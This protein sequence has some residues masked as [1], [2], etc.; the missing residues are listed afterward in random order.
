MGY[1][2]DL[3]IDTVITAA[4]QEHEK[5]YRRTLQKDS[6]KQPGAAAHLNEQNKA[7]QQ[8]DNAM[9]RVN[10]VLHNSRNHSQWKDTQP[11]DK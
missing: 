11:Q 8:V 5:N 3:L 1:A 6:N 4:T 9:P 10:Q 7:R 2:A